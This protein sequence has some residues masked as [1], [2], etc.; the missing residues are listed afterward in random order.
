MLNVCT[1]SAH[2]F[3]KTFVQKL[4]IRWFFM[5]KFWQVLIY[6]SNDFQLSLMY[7]FQ[8]LVLMLPSCTP[9][10]C[11]SKFMK[12][13]EFTTFPKLLKLPV[14]YTYPKILRIL[15]FI[16]EKLGPFAKMVWSTKTKKTS[17]LIIVY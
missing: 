8:K 11:R 7:V 4:I 14:M 5:M 10:L 13:N 3:Y 12:F 9:K 1:F 15:E 2:L 6:F 17:I 16:C